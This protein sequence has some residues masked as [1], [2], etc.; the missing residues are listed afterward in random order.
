MRSEHYKVFIYTDKHVIETVFNLAEL[1]EFERWFSEPD[2]EMDIT[3]Q[4]IYTS[5]KLPFVIDNFIGIKASNVTAYV[6]DEYDK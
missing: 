1:I 3:S 2:V 5:N 4:G 6:A